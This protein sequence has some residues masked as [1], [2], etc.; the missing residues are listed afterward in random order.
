MQRQNINIGNEEKY[1]MNNATKNGLREDL[2]I[3]EAHGH[4]LFPMPV[5]EAV[6]LFRKYIEFYGVEKLQLLSVPHAEASEGD[7]IHNLKLFY[8]K[9]RLSPNAY[10]AA[11]LYHALDDTDSADSFLQQAKT[12]YDIGADGFKMLEG[13]PSVYKSLGGIPLDDAVYDKFYSFAEEKQAPILM[14]I[15]DPDY[16]WDEEKCSDYIKKAGWC[17][18]QTF[19]LKEE[20]H[21]ETECVLKKHP[22]LKLIL[23]HFSFLADDIDRCARLFDTYPNL[24]F[25]LTPGA[26]EFLAFSQ[27][28]D[29]WKAFFRKYSSRL[30]YGS[31][32]YN[33]RLSDT[34]MCAN[35]VR[36]N[37]LRGFLETDKEIDV[38]G[39][40]VTGFKLDG[41]ILKDIYYNNIY[42]L[43]GE[44]RPLNY[45][46]MAAECARLLK[47]C[48]NEDLHMINAFL[49]WVV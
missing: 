37:Q 26:G 20:L 15:A 32:S 22:D 25:D 6:E 16:F 29:E 17:Y 43:L 18:D 35:T 1:I 24:Y 3:F 46:V 21:R 42:K 45:E 5:D 7:P 40:K 49:E 44:P 4:L 36:I 11:G 27:K 38:L 31:D 14:H 9:S 13:K 48:D 23:A 12:A 39:Q 8:A 47:Y 34:M 33:F 41:D 10:V 19:P 30:I 28:P 2:K